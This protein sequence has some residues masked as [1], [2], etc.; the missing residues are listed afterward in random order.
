MCGRLKTPAEINEIRIELR[1]DDFL[2]H[3]YAPRYNTAPT[4]PVPVITSA[5]GKRTLEMMRWGLIPYWAKD[6]KVGFSSFNARAESVATAPAFRDAWKRDQ[7][8]LVIADG[9]YEW[10]KPDKQPFFI[11]LGQSLADGVCRAYGTDGA[12]RTAIAILQPGSLCDRLN[13]EQFRQRFCLRAL[14]VPS[15]YAVPQRSR[16]RGT[17][18]VCPPPR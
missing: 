2:I 14:L 5:N 4:D 7:R 12:R 11:S 13:V 17:S 6:I 9:F 15:P 16:L 10:R 3:D 8:C 18:N 1:I